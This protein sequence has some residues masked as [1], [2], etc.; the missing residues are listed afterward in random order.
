MVTWWMFCVSYQLTGMLRVTGMRP[1]NISAARVRQ[2]AKFGKLTK[3][4]V[5]TRSN[6]SS[7]RSGRTAVCSVWLSTA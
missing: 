5:P 7:M 4:R 3:A 6:S 1:P 2:C